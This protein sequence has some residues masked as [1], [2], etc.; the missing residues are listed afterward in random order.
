MLTSV[1][2]YKQTNKAMSNYYKSKIIGKSATF[3]TDKRSML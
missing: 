2:I 1:Q 3:F